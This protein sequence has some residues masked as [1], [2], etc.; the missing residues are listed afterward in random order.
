[1]AYK[2]NFE[3]IIIIFNKMG[4]VGCLSSKEGKSVD[5]TIQADKTDF[6]ALFCLSTNK[7]SDKDVQHPVVVKRPSE[8]ADKA[9]TISNPTKEDLNLDTSM[10]E[11]AQAENQ[12]QLGDQ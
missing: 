11:I 7:K 5:N 1:M 9:I 12:I 4:A 3:F 8:D 2:T 6:A 10:N